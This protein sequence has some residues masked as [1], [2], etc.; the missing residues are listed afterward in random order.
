MN[1]AVTGH[2]P[3]RLGQ[4]NPDRLVDLA[5]AALGK[6]RPT[7]VITGM[8][9]GWDV[10]VAKAAMKLKIN[11]LAVI[12]HLDQH[13]QHASVSQY[14]ELLGESTQPVLVIGE[15]LP[16]TKA[17][18]ARNRWMV[19]RAELVLSLFDGRT[20]GGT[21]HTVWYAQ[22]KGVRVVNLWASWQKGKGQ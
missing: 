5:V 6:Y 3:K 21:Y 2:R 11:F 14:W 7:L 10:A 19:D 16:P 22:A 4:H 18:K 13:K 20:Y 9:P 12:P 1:I 8:S 17:Y 15:G